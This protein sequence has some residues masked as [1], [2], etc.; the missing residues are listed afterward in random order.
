MKNWNDIYKLP[1]H[2]AKYGT[3]VYDAE[4]NFVFQFEI[5]HDY[6]REEVIDILNGL[7]EPKVKHKS[8]HKDGFIYD[9]VGEIMITIRG[10]GNLRG[11]GAHN[12][13]GEEAAN[14]QDTFANWIVERLNRK[15]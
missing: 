12:L 5:L 11:V 9:D 10:W 3:W 2:L 6:T 1:L 8:I 14:I 4:S 15:Q 7:L 13:S